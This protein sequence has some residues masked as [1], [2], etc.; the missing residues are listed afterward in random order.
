MSYEWIVEAVDRRRGQARPQPW[1]HLQGGLT[2]SKKT[3]LSILP[4]TLSSYDRKV[5]VRT[6]FTQPSGSC[7]AIPISRSRDSEGGKRSTLPLPS[8]TRLTHTHTNSIH[9][10]SC[11]QGLLLTLYFEKGNSINR[12]CQNKGPPNNSKGYQICKQ[13]QTLFQTQTS[14]KDF[15][16]SFCLFSPW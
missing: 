6:R 1:T 15:T 14:Y 10:Y 16:T 5:G 11:P 9:R 4:I 2:V 7:T 12:T 3:V 8:M 13:F